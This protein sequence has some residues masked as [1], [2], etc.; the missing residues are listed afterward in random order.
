MTAPPP[1]AAAATWPSGVHFERLGVHFFL[2]GFAAG[3]RAAVS[4]PLPLACQERT[5]GASLA[6]ILPSGPSGPVR[7]PSG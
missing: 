1:G 4:S 7:L 6:V 3:S 5:R 2:P